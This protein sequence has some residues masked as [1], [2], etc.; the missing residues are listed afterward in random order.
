MLSLIL[1][2]LAALCFVLAAIGRPVFPWLPVG[3]TL[4]TLAFIFGGMGGLDINIG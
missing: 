2:I 4:L 1:L 3:L